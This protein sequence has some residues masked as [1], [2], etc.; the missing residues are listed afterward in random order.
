MV[1]LFSQIKGTWRA[2]GSQEWRQEEEEKKNLRKEM[3][4]EWQTE[5][6]SSCSQLDFFQDF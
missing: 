6:S 3:E 2:T 5:R 1:G 4:S